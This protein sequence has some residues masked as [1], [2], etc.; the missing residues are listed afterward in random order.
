[1]HVDGSESSLHEMTDRNNAAPAG[2]SSSSSAAA[3]G[4]KPSLRFPPRIQSN[5]MSSVPLTPASVPGPCPMS[6]SSS[7]CGGV[8]QQDASAFERQ[9]L[10]TLNKVHQ[11]IEK[12]EFRLAEQDRRDAVKHD[13]QQVALVVDRLLLLIFIVATLGITAAILFHAPHSREF[14]FG[15]LFAAHGSSG[16]GPGNASSSSS[17]SAAVEST[18]FPSM[19]ASE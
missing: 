3:A 11:T 14:L 15:G 19:A 1:M 4:A 5:S 16:D 12:N 6:G 2:N 18:D 8:Q 10:R 9:F 13:W 7:S 17:S